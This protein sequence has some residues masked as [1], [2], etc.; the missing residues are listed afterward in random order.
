MSLIEPFQAVINL[1]VLLLPVI[2]EELRPSTTLT[3]EPAK[4]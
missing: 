2:H 4:K 3:A 1:V